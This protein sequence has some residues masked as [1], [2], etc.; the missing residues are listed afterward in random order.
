MKPLVTTSPEPALR[1][2]GGDLPSAPYLL[3]DL[4]AQRIGSDPARA[5]ITFGENTT[6]YAHLGRRAGAV[7]QKLKDLGVRRGDPVGVFLHRH[8]DLVAALLGIWWA[9]AAYVPLDPNHPDERLAWMADDAGVRVTVTRGDLT[10]RVGRLSQLKTLVLDDLPTAGSPVGPLVDVSADDAAYVMYTSGSTG[11]PKGIV[12]GHGGI[13]NRVLWTVRTHG[14][15]PGDRVLQKTSTGFDAA[16]W[17]FF[18]P[19]VSGATVALAPLGAERDP[20]LM[21]RAIAEQDIT[22]LQGVPSV[23]RRLVTEPAWPDCRCLRL[24]FSAGEP[25]DAALARALSLEGQAQ[26]WNTYGPTECSIDVTA[27][28]SDPSAAEGAVPIG[29]PLDNL[30]IL[31]LEPSGEPVPVG[32]PGEVHVGGAG[33]GRGYLNQA[34]LTAERFV[35]DPYGERGARLYRTGDQARW[36]SDG[37]LEFLGRLD[38][39]VK[40][41]GVRIEPG[42]VEAALLGHPAVQNAAV[43]VE[44]HEQARRLVG[45]L[46]GP[47]LPSADETRAYLRE[48]VP[49]VMIPARFV[50]LAEFPLNTSGKTDRRA[51]AAL[52]PPAAEREVVPPR[53]AAEEL[54]A[55]IWRELL[56]VDEVSVDDDFF[57]L[58]ATSLDVTRLATRLRARC[59]RVDL[60]GLFG[61]STLAGQAALIGT[62]ASER[63]TLTGTAGAGRA[64]EVGQAGPDQGDPIG[65][66]GSE[67]A[68]IRRVPRTGPLPLSPGQHRLRFLDSLNPGSP[69]WVAPLFLRLPAGADE[70]NV[71]RALHHIEQRHESLRTRYPGDDGQ[72]VVAAGQVELRVEHS[73]ALEGL[74]AEQFARGFDLANGPLWRALLVH[75]PG[76]D[77]VLLVT[78]HHIASDGWSTAVL[79]RELR[80]LI[81][82]GGAEDLPELPVQYA[83]YAHWQRRH[84]S[85]E[86]LAGDLAYWRRQLAGAVPTELLPDHPRPARRDAAGAGVQVRI[87]AALAQSIEKFS[88]AQG[89][90]P[91][92]TLLTALAALLAR[93]TGSQDVVIG[94]PV[95]GRDREE[96]SNV[97]GF[98][99]NS[100]VLRC[101]LDDDPDALTAVQRV[102]Q[103]CAE[104][105]AHQSV[106]FERL[107]NELQPQRDLSR[108]P[109]YQVAFDLQE[110]GATTMSADPVV[111]AAFQQAWKVSKTDLTLFVRRGENGTLDAAFEYAAALFDQ[112]TVQ[113]LADRY[114][115]LLRAI[116]AKPS[117]RLSSIDLVP[118]AERRQLQR[119][120]V[121]PGP[122]PLTCVHED[123]RAAG[124]ANPQAVA[125]ESG[126]HALTYAELEAASNRIAHHLTGLI[127]GQSE[128]TVAV[129]LDRGSDLITTMLGIWKAGGAYVPLDPSFPAERIADMAETAGTTVAVTSSAYAQRFPQQMRTVALDSSTLDVHPDTPLDV[130]A[131]PDRLAYV[132]FT[133]GSTGRPKGVAVTHRGLAN[134]VHWA[135]RELAGQGTGGAPLFSS[136]AF[137]LVVPNLWAPLV[138]GQR[139]WMYPQSAELDGLGKALAGAGSFSFVKLTPGHLELLEHQLTPAQMDRLAEVVVV[140]GEA[141]AGPLAQRWR[142]VLGDARLINEYG[143]TEA[144][145]GTCVHPVTGQVTSDVVPIGRPL[146]NLSMR[147]LEPDGSPA[148][149]AVPGELWVGGVGVARG[150]I[151]RP[152]LTAERFAPDPWGPPGA[153]MYRTGD[154]ARVNADGAVEFLGRIDDQVKIRGYRVEP[155]EIRARLLENPEIEDAVVVAAGPL[156]DQRLL[157][158]Y[159]PAATGEVNDLASYCAQRL[160]AY[161]VPAVFIALPAIPLT[162]NGK[163]DRSSLPEPEAKSALTAPRNPAEERVAQIWA[164]VL[165]CPEE[166]VDVHTGFFAAGGHSIRAVQL[167][168]EL[169]SAFGVQLSIRA[170]F[171]RPTVAELAEEIEAAI[172]AEIEQMT[173]TDLLASVQN[174]VQEGNS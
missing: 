106:P 103:T 110:E 42:E 49:E 62:A 120:S 118:A 46:A 59:G 32:V 72:V 112:T 159:V 125:V 73:E 85:D 75:V 123:I 171:E 82:G 148:P 54:I 67:Q 44:E 174:Q 102:R 48:R 135:A 47:D 84:T 156:T 139:V 66:G 163:L 136:V 22:V 126:L 17:E 25:L 152:D 107:V 20:E 162:A 173:A 113:R 24:V 9:G 81:S 19:L 157:A 2:G 56:G 83:D 143:P 164:G 29:R 33:L 165:G 121:N 97:V 41:N 172:R 23:L 140:A 91:F 170:V 101:R 40:V 89:V 45:Y 34:A 119:W 129:L 51:L 122:L 141:L 70:V 147:V 69:E 160:P 4:V 76:Q 87:P 98:F 90:T 12:I 100:V 79:E 50:H 116:V 18:A 167:I 149:I 61:A 132:I 21:V 63:A 37:S 95:A 27:H 35:P 80:H 5:A 16:V 99:L 131:D 153:R 11:R 146:P 166:E 58:G 127:A 169:K 93:H 43:L 154:L 65:T 168:S 31:L 77:P 137:D 104:A 14:L 13:A 64:G 161:L 15:G 57:S 158:Y 133:S 88:R 114:M 155:G 92:T 142:N 74:F 115:R 28:R 111:N 71:R 1:G 7:A 96:L 30:R 105:F 145:V 53:N 36:R 108:T 55:E 124:Q 109:L 6:D 8:P 86:A 134:H 60:P 150:Y 94:T 151:G 78:V 130:P 10:S 3:P 26:V 138:A 52:A 38:G 144:S 68:E 117:R 39:Q 128:P